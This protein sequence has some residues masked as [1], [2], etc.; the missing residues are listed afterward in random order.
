MVDRITRAFWGCCAIL[1][2]SAGIIAAPP[3]TITDGGYWLTVVDSAGVPS[4]VRVETV[5]DL[6]SG[7]DPA[8]EPKPTPE[9]PTPPTVD[10]D[11]DVVRASKAAAESINDPN[12]AQ[13]I[14]AVYDHV[15]GALADGLLDANSVWPAL[16]TATDDALTIT[17]STV[18]WSA[19]RSAMSTLVTER[20]QRGTLADA[21]QISNV[22]LSIAQGASMAA[23][24]KPALED[25][26]IF[27]IAIKTNEAIDA[28]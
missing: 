8:P 13:A 27:A 7:D 18:N 17:S 2:L 14:K 4:L 20:R 6:R 10:Y 1:W 9:T 23:D 11:L 16:K 19:F 26:Q 24:G 28:Q 12:G 5:V 15:A 22:L 21:N 3:L 25:A